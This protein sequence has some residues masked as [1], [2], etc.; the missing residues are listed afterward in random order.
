MVADVTL[1]DASGASTASGL[2]PAACTCAITSFFTHVWHSHSDTIRMWGTG[3]DFIQH[4]Y[5][6]TES[7]SGLT[8]DS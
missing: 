6:L 4:E 8:K 3:K 5:G 1:V 7:W 2:I